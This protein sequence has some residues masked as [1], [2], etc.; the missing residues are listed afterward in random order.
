ML[1]ENLSLDQRMREAEIILLDTVS[2]NRTALYRDN[3]ELS[4]ADKAL[5]FERINR[6]AAGEPIQYILGEVEFMSLRIK[7]G[8]GVLIPRPES[9][10]WLENLILWWQNNRGKS[11]GLILDLCTGS[12][13]LALALAQ[14]FAGLSVIGLDKSKE[15]LEFARYNAGLNR[16][17]N[18]VFVRGDLL[19]AIRPGCGGIDLLVSNPPYVSASEFKSL[20]PEVNRWEP[21]E[22]LVGGDDGLDFYRLIIP[23]AFGLL[24]PQG[25]LAFEVGSSQGFAVRKL[26]HESGI[27]ETRIYKDYAGLDRAV[28]GVKK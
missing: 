5:F 19:S 27:T 17:S 28:F 14:H 9:E 24:A 18:V 12:G 8:P 22:A 25:L 13:C 4:A 16:I 3:P 21:S 6:R 2:I 26:M 11:P 20:D 1:A 7:V 10:C 15:A 23:E